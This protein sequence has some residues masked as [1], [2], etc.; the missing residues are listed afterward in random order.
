[1]VHVDPARSSTVATC[2][3]KAKTKRCEGK[4]EGSKKTIC[5]GSCSW[6]CECVQNLT[7]QSFAGRRET[8][9][10]IWAVW[11]LYSVTHKLWP[12]LTKIFF[13]SVPK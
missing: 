7:I 9:L 1:M 10:E 6:F 8:P 13:Y 3:K 5:I 4:S 2:L 12:R 11:D